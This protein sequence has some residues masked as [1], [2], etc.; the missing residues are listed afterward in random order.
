[1]DSESHV[2]Q[3]INRCLHYLFICISFAFFLLSNIQVW[4]KTDIK[5]FFRQ[6]YGSWFINRMWARPVITVI[7]EYFF[8]PRAFTR[9]HKAPPFGII[10]AASAPLV[11]TSTPLQVTWVLLWAPSSCRRA[12]ARLIPAAGV[13]LTAVCFLVSGV[14]Q[15][16]VE[17]LCWIAAVD[18]VWLP[19]RAE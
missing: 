14:H 3:E 9:H 18:W 1:M 2:G 6:D 5:C 7:P 11:P 12:A 10:M 4:K 15:T 19:R 13:T 16:Q 17:G 8:F